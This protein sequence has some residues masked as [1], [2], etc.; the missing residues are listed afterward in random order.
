V[1][2]SPWFFNENDLEGQLSVYSDGNIFLSVPRET[3]LI[4]GIQINQIINQSSLSTLEGKR[5]ASSV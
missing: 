3:R 5:L 1:S 2:S 4:L